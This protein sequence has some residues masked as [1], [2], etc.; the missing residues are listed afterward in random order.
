MLAEPTYGGGVKGKRSGSSLKTIEKGKEV[1]GEKWF[2]DRE[3]L[4]LEI[5][6]VTALDM[7]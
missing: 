4:A 2:R 5:K 1:L 7:E 3:N 6:A